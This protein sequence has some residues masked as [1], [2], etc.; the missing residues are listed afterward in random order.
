MARQLSK[1]QEEVPYNNLTFA[2]EYSGV[3]AAPELNYEIDQEID[4]TDKFGIH[5]DSVPQWEFN[6]DEMSSYY[7][8][9]LASRFGQAYYSENALIKEQR[10]LFDSTK[11][12]NIGDG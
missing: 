12:E 3:G 6:Q 4:V 7:D 11:K 2:E 1:K 8:G 5:L 10:H 9:D